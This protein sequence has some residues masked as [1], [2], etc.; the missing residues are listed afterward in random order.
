MTD[1]PD[2]TPILRGGELPRADR[3]ELLAHLHRCSA[4]RATLAD[5]DS[6]A[7]FS[8]LALEPVPD[9]VLARV[10]RGV[11][12]GIARES[13][14]A[15]SRRIYALGSLAA[16]VLLAASLGVYLWTQNEGPGASPIPAQL[17]DLETE[18][19]WEAESAMPAGFFEVLDSPSSAD[20]IRIAVEEIDFVMIFDAELDI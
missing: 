8:L 5:Q 13:R 14:R 3:Q 12:D 10:S 11:A 4:C 19:T 17:V 18:T 15:S 9:T 7:L 2:L 16:S 20:V 1:H 6:S